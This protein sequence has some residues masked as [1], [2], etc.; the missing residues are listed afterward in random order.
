MAGVEYLFGLFSRYKSVTRLIR[1][2]LAVA[3][4][5]KWTFGNE[6]LLT[7]RLEKLL[8]PA[9]CP[10]S[11]VVGQRRRHRFARLGRFGSSQPKSKFVGIASRD[12]RQRLIRSKE[13]QQIVAGTFKIYPRAWLYVSPCSHVIGEESAERSKGRIACWFVNQ[14]QRRKPVA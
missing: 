8:C 7:G 4:V 6:L 2:Y 12:S 1:P 11:R 9:A 13:G 5:C 14:T 10:P 3:N